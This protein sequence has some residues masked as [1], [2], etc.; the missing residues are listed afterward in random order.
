M[1]AVFGSLNKGENVTSGLKKV[2][3]DMKTKNRTDKTSVVPAEVSAKKE[4][5]AAPKAATKVKP[6]K[7]GLD[8]NKWSVEN[9][10]DKKDIVISETE[11]RHTVYIYGLTNSTVQV[12]GKVNSVAIDNCK[13]TAVVVENVISGV[14]VVNG[15][16]IEVQ[17]TG[18]APS[19]AIDKT[20]G[21]QLYLSKDGL[22]TEIVTSKISEMNVLL[23]VEGQDDLVEL[24][25]PEQYK[26]WV[27]GGK[28]VTETVQHSG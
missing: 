4:T 15:T 23:P 13:R 19:V 28:L 11:S 16:S 21:M 8:G 2:T 25:V 24:P 10:V 22:D 12:K 7:F 3:D 6:P 27:R 5:G 9:F 20:S 14:E 18:R 26:T 17:I 1:T